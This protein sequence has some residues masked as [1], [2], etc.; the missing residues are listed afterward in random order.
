MPET[1]TCPRCESE[2]SHHPVA[3]RVDDTIAICSP[4]GADEAMRAFAG[5]P[6]IPPNEWPTIERFEMISEFEPD[7]PCFVKVSIGLVLNTQ[8]VAQAAE[9]ATSFT[10]LLGVSPLR[11]SLIESFVEEI[12][13]VQ[14]DDDE[15][16]PDG[17]S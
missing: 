5:Q 12:A 2:Y 15:E 11:D 9:W 17:D 1:Q 10:G 13:M 3:S 16:A 8:D 14:R 7:K 6:P 4:C